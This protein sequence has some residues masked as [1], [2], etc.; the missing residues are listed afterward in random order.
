MEHGLAAAGKCVVHV[1]Q[2]L[3]RQQAHTPPW[4]SGSSRGLGLHEEADGAGAGA[5]QQLPGQGGC[6][7]L[8][9]RVS[10]GGRWAAGGRETS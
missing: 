9:K 7:W 8:P 3:H 2:L 5:A 1:C 4:G 6:P 10:L